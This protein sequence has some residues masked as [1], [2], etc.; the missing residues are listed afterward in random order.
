MELS[1][2]THFTAQQ[3]MIGVC[4]QPWL[5]AD[6]FV[7]TA[8]LN[9]IHSEII[10]G[11]TLAE[12][13]ILSPGG[14][15]SRGDAAEELYDHNY[16]C[17]GLAEK[18]LTPDEHRF[19]SS[20][21]RN[22]KY[23]FLKFAKG[24][25][26]PWSYVYPI[27]GSTDWLKK[28]DPNG[29]GPSQEAMIYFPKLLKW[30]YS[31]PIF[32]SIGRVSIFGVD[33]GHHITCHRDVHP[34]KYSIDDELLMV[35]PI[36]QKPFYIYDQVEKKKHYIIDTK[37][38]IFHDCDFHGVDAVPY[39]SYNFRIDGVFTKEFRNKILYGREAR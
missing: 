10:R 32:A 6:A 8:S 19:Y 7:N 15:W 4:G 1:T 11:L 9:E 20:L 30:I 14:E 27:V 16:K 22:Q 18:D 33:H 28:A 37:T 17:I 34:E 13:F 26:F 39:F 21:N 12:N 35:D 31:L 25:Y 36:G 5:S 23:K 24:G 29:K 3:K 2:D 38:W